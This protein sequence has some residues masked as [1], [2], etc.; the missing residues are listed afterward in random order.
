MD[1]EPATIEQVRLG[2]TG[3][4]HTFTVAES[5][6]AADLAAIARD[7]NTTFI[8]RF[9][10]ETG[11]YSVVQKYG[12]REDD[13]QLVATAAHKDSL[14]LVVTE[15]RHMVNRPEDYDLVGRLDRNEAQRERDLERATEERVGEW[16]QEAFHKLRKAEGR[17]D[18]IIVPRSV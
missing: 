7:A 12:P 9:H 4:V 10:E 2:K 16:A 15:V 8:L 1:I 6:V 17:T 14:P 13:E 18:R 3:R 5:Q 11:H